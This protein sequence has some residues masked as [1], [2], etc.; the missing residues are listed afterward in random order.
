MARVRVGD[1]GREA[2]PPRGERARGE[3]R[4]DVAEEALVGE[5]EVVVA[6]RLGA[7]RERRQLAR[8]ARGQQEQSGPEAHG[9]VSPESAS[10]TFSAV[11]GRVVTRTPTAAATAFATA[12]GG[13]MFGG[14]PTPLAP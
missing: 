9:A 7:R 8:R 11:I 6:E 12:A 5:P 3:A 1:A 2:D 10:A 14:S 4:V 13:S